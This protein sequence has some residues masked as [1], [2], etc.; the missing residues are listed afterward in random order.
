LSKASYMGKPPFSKPSQS[1][2]TRCQL[3]RKGELLTKRFCL[4]FKG[5]FMG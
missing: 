5:K 4:S 2:L 1:S 3:P